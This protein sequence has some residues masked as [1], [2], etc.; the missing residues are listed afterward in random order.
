VESAYDFKSIYFS[1]RDLMLFIYSFGLQGCSIQDL[2]TINL[3]VMFII[4]RLYYG[5]LMQGVS[6][7]A[8]KNSSGRITGKGK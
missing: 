8:G 4:G 5:I 2:Q 6:A 7:M 3:T 1:F